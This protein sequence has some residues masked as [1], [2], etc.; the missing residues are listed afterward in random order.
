MASE[1]IVQMPKIDVLENTNE[2][3]QT[4][5]AAFAKNREEVQKLNRD[6]LEKTNVLVK[7][8]GQT[9]LD[10]YDFNVKLTESWFAIVEDS[11]RTANGIAKKAVAKAA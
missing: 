2:M 5:L 7:A 1:K 11:V 4:M 3:V 9:A 6:V 8:A 10:L